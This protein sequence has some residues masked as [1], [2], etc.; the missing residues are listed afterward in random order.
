M[1]KRV[2][3]M[4]KR[5]GA[6]LLAIVLLLSLMPMQY[7]EAAYQDDYAKLIEGNHA[8]DALKYLGY[9]FDGLIEDEKLF[10]IWTGD[11][12]KPY[13]TNIKWTNWNGTSGRETQP[14]GEGDISATGKV[15]DVALFEKQ[16]FECGGFVTYYYYNYLVNIAGVDISDLTKY[17]PSGAPDP[18]PWVTALNKM[19]SKDGSAKLMIDLSDDQDS[20]DV[21]ASIWNKLTPGDLLFFKTHPVYDENG[22]VV[23]GKEGY[24]YGHICI[25]VGMF[26]CKDKGV[27]PWMMH[28]SSSKG[29]C[30][31]PVYSIENVNNGVGVDAE[32]ANQTLNKIFHLNIDSTYEPV[33]S[34]TIN[35][36]DKETGAPLSGAV[37]TA[38]NT[39][40]GE[41]HMF[42]AT[43][44]SG[45]TKMKDLPLGTY[46][47]REITPPTNYQMPTVNTWTVE[48]TSK[49][50][51]I[52]F[53]VQ[54]ELKHG[55]IAAQKSDEF[56][57]PL[58]RVTFGIYSDAACRNQ[59]GTMMTDDT[60]VAKSSALDCTK[61]YYVKE[62]KTQSADYVLDTTVHSV[63]VAADA[64]VW[65]N[66]G[67][68][69]VNYLK[70][71]AVGIKKETEYNT[72]LAGVTYGV[73]AD[74]AC[75]KLLEK[76]TTDLNG[77]AVYG[78]TANGDYTIR[79]RQTVYFKELNPASDDYVLDTNVYPV[80]VEAET[81][82]WANNGEPVV[83]Y[84]KR[85]AVAV[86]KVDEEG[87][88]LANATFGAYS[89]A[90][91]KNL[92]GFFVTDEKGIGTFGI[93][94]ETGEYT[95]V[96]NTTIY[97]RE[98]MAPDDTWV[99]N[100]TIYPVTV[101]GDKVVYANNGNPIVNKHKY[102]QITF[103]KKDSENNGLT[104]GDASVVGAVYGL[105]NSEDQL[106]DQYTVGENG[107][108]TTKKY[109]VGEGFY[110]KE[111]SAPSGYKLDTTEYYLD[112]YTKPD[113]S[114]EPLTTHT[115]GLKEIVMTGTV[116]LSKFTADPKKPGIYNVPE[117]GAEFQV[118]L[119]SAGSYEN[120]VA[121][122]D[123]RLYDNGA[124]NS[125]GDIVWS[126]GSI[127]S[128][129]LAYGTYIVHQVSSWDNRIFVEDFEITIL[130]DSQHF[131]F[132]LNNP[133]YTANI[134]VNKRDAESG[135]LIVNGV[136]AF[137]ILNVDTNE[138]VVYRDE[139][140]GEAIDEF[141][142]VDGM[143]T[144]P[145]ELPYGNY[146]LEETRAPEGYLLNSEPITFVIDKNSNGILTFN[147]E[148]EPLMGKLQ[149][150][151]KGIQFVSV[152]Q[153]DTNYG[154]VFAPVYEEDFIA[155]VRFNVIAD[156]DI[157]TGD[158]VVH[159]KK[160][161][162]VDT[163][164]TNGD[165]AV[166]SKDLY[167]GKYLLVEIE[168]PDGVIMTHDAI[169]IEVANPGQ[170]KV[171]VTPV[172]IT[173]DY[174]ATEVNM[175]KRA[176]TWEA[177]TVAETGEVTRKLNMVSGVGFTF[178]LFA[179]E[180]FTAKS[181]DL[182]S[183]DSLVAV[184]VTNEL[185]AIHLTD[186][187]PYGKYYIKE[188]DT[189][190][191]HP[192]I[193]DA[194][195][196]AVDLSVENSRNNVIV[197]DVNDG[198]AVI[199][200]FVNF[201]VAIKKTDLTSA[202][203][204]KGA[205]VSI[206]NAAGDTIYSVY[207]DEEGKL[208]GVLLEPGKYT[209]TEDIAPAGYIREPETFEFEVLADGTVEG[210]TEFTNEQTVIELFKVDKG[211]QEPLANAK[212]R[213]TNSAGEVVYEGVTDETG[214]ITIVGVLNP[215]ESYEFTE[216]ETPNG[217]AITATVYSFTVNE[218]GTITGSNTVENEKTQFSIYKTSPDGLPLAGA[219]FTMYDVDG[220]VLDVQVTGEDGIAT[221]IGFGVGT[222]I[223]RETKAP[224]GYE[225]IEGD[226]VITNDG[227]WDN[228]SD[229]ARFT[230]VNEPI[231]STGDITMP[232]TIAGIAMGFA[233]FMLAA[234]VIFFK[235]KIA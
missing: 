141:M 79:C 174:V 23:E 180:D 75:T 50:P 43:D 144:L 154:P 4:C 121:T 225:L 167:V 175:L 34:I 160:G 82:T 159:Y 31:V 27:I 108:F 20:S 179:A 77:E 56:G 192:Y 182:I 16:G 161:D 110:L 186:R 54:N 204:V 118:Y 209:F 92:L 19:E 113:G 172:Q 218:D 11:A 91:C 84:L 5:V 41:V 157:V 171:S 198:E 114:N 232:T 163:I 189:P 128:K 101:A 95:L 196:Y 208:P 103:E 44:A 131:N 197:V 2:K 38:A 67:E 86:G 212:I 139:E 29:S 142:T 168:A 39:K 146:Q 230:F 35:K 129:D 217:Y 65:V 3:E 183:G 216:I 28:Q 72:P 187:L 135:K 181:G 81:A 221:F 22:D 78:R 37:F 234:C 210:T 195:A 52:T 104:A 228:S 70:N 138:Y 61:T 107:S 13:L 85:G 53:D 164:V 136:A 219:E 97:V 191:D 93:D 151:K 76:V 9:D 74:S 33:G 7:A 155:G 6:G 58:S 127:V 112:D 63:V 201:S 122:G 125:N 55:F 152:S 185:G 73:Y 140:T 96:C 36:S 134:V 119:K 200:E 193:M 68:W 106:L 148:N 137:K 14:A 132:N 10:Q 145:M 99:L 143:M 89:D 169:E 231:P 124:A 57:N 88:P 123:K 102:W 156:E 133:Y 17:L 111:I 207:T 60:G 158:G 98:I 178:G 235:K 150:D 199:N 49:T 47:V 190:K 48:I 64:T 226:I 46:T 177:V 233:L 202:A 59:I 32:K 149:I 224:E 211:T 40:T 66:N 206:K 8:I 147:V 214:K 165:A 115:A 62:T 153:K 170:Q 69:I 213:V 87:N 12:I 229:M 227:K 71:G 116:S 184:M 83:N 215:G 126:N 25:F 21:P 117:V 24:E 26:P 205:L 109:V 162:I 1:Y 51:H 194:K 105:Y 42:P 45:T 188:L 176:Y 166:C 90:A 130:D 223:V 220:N 100:Q 222:F 18:A 80:A 120:A 94:E 173:N 203:P 15:P 30:M